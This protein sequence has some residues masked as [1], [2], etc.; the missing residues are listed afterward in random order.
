VVDEAAGGREVT[1]KRGR[2]RYLA[3][4]SALRYLVAGGLSFLVD[5]GLLAL[6]HEVFG[7]DV[8][9]ATAVAFLAS[10]AFTYTIQKLFAFSSPSP[11][12]VSLLKYTALVIFNT[13]ATVAIV[14]M[15]D[16]SALGWG[17]GKVAATCVTTVWNYFAYKYWVFA[18]PHRNRRIA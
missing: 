2:L 7:W 14:A 18:D 15:I 16:A 17:V 5:F 13:L 8:W 10:F 4:H 9:L 6:G 3:N 11:H 12:G 1:G